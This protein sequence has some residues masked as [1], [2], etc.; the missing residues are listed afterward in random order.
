MHFPLF[1]GVLCLSLFFMHYFVFI[2]DCNHLEK[3]GKRVI[4]L[5]LSYRCIITIN[6]LWFFLTVPWVGLPSVIV[7][8]PDHSHLLFIPYS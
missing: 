1:A 4:L 2:L 6:V 8:F 7:I 3:E 5:F